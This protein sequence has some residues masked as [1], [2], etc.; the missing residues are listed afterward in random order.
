MPL[1]HPGRDRTRGRI[2]RVVY[3][4]TPD[5]PVAVPSPPDLTKLDLDALISK[6][7]D[8]N[9]VVRTTATHEIRDRFAAESIPRILPQLD[10]LNANQRAHA[11]YILAQPGKMDEDFLRLLKKDDDASVRVHAV[12]PLAGVATTDRIGFINGHS[13]QNFVGRLVDKDPMVRRA[14]FEHLGAAT[15]LFIP[16]LLSEWKSIADKDTHLTHAL[17]IALRDC[18]K[19]ADAYQTPSAKDE[20]NFPQIADVSLGIPSPDAAA[21]VFTYIEKDPQATPRFDEMLGHVLRH[22]PADKLADA[23]KLTEKLRDQPTARSAPF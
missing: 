4:G 1:D 21:F 6:L 3:K 22:L 8:A 16:I 23:F 20:D 12:A 17:R 18:F 7:D 2:W 13:C 11:T 5:K 9:L 19:Y 14:A 10:K 15:P